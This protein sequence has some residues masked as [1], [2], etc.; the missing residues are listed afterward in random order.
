VVNETDDG[1]T[2]PPNF[3]FISENQLGAGV[4]RAEASFRSGCECADPRDCMY[5]DCLCLEDL[6][7]EDTDSGSDEDRDEDED[8]RTDGEKKRF[9]YYYAGARAGLLKKRHLQS[10]KPIYECHEGCGCGPDCPNRVVERGRT[11]P[12]QIFRTDDG[13]GWGKFELLNLSCPRDLE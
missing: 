6:D 5:G 11:V 3:R 2:L 9:S 7:G 13:R 1:E 4:S 8:A 12:L 10:R